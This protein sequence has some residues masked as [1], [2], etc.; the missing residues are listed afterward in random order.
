LCK[1]IT[2]TQ[3]FYKYK[4]NG[5]YK[6]GN[7]Y[8]MEYN[9]SRNKL[10]IAEY[11]RNIQKMVEYALTIEDDEKRNALAKR[12][13]AIM[14]SIN[15][16]TGNYDDISH[17][18]WDHLFIISGFKLIVDSPFPMPDR[19]KVEAKPQ[20][21]EYNDGRIRN[22]TYG[23][24]LEN[25]IQK[26]IEFEEGKEKEALV[27]L[28]ANNLKKAYLLWNSNSV[29]D[30]QIIK[31][32]ARMSDGKLELPEDYVFPSSQDLIGKKRVYSK[33][34][35]KNNQNKG[36]DKNSNYRKSNRSENQGRRDNRQNKQQTSS[37]NYKKRPY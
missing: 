25:M 16:S 1:N 3:W 21:I 30:S 29:D 24:N 5:V 36:R 2:I 27:A 12:I 26:A 13:V 4:N 22:R 19:D 20:V 7:I 33:D 28:L 15:T 37:K 18:I 35:K 8:Q 31:D 17:K 14:T 23:R 34:N 9:T 32:L 10:I 6:T 11:G